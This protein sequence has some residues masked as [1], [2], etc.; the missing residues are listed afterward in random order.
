MTGSNVQSIVEIDQ[1]EDLPQPLP[2]MIQPERGRI[3][4]SWARRVGRTGVAAFPSIPRQKLLDDRT[5]K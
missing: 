1:G 5:P 3:E 4:R 2:D